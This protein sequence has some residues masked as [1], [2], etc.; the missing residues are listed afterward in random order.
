[1]LTI[2]SIIGNVFQNGSLDEKFKILD[3]SGRCERLRIS[4]METERFRLRKKTDKGTDIGLIIEAKQN[5]HHG[6]V[7]LSTPRKM[8][9]VE[10]LPEKV[11]SIVLKTNKIPIQHLIKIGHILGNRH[12]PIAINPK[13]VVFFPVDSDSELN[14]FNTLMRDITHYIQLNLEEQVFQPQGGYNINE[15]HQ[16]Q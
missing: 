7:L 16:H 11:I 3:A 8:I 10:Q 15:E 6:D 9:I 1:M 5:L 2:K 12:K 14:V 4:R 13:G